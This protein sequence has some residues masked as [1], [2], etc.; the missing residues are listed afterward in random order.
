MNRNGTDYNR[1]NLKSIIFKNAVQAF[2]QSNHIQLFSF[3]TEDTG[4]FQADKKVISIDGMK[5]TV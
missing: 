2:L 1:L 4:L 3:F 5:K